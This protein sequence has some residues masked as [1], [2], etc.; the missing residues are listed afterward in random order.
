[1]KLTTEQ[2]YRAREELLIRKFELEEENSD[3]VLREMGI[4]G[5][6]DEIFNAGYEL[7]VATGKIVLINELLGD[8]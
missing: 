3:E 1:M 2:L 4:D 5:D 7:G 6:T 8:K